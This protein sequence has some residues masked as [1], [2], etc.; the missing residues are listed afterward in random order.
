MTIATGEYSKSLES[1][2]SLNE[3]TWHITWTQVV[4]LAALGAAAVV[5]HRFLRIPLGLAGRH[6]V[7]WMML[8]VAGRALSRFRGASSI[9][10]ASAAGFSLMPYWGT[11]GEPLGWLTYLAAGVVIDLAVNRWP[12]FRA[13]LWAL[14]LLGALGHAMKPLL[15]AAVTLVT[16]I[17]FHSLLSGLLYPLST[18]LM[19]GAAGGFL[20]GVA[21]TGVRLVK[22]KT[23]SQPPVV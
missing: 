12:A 20:G 21:A 5:L 11:S 10:A 22:G 2:N 7:E 9:T 15:R 4:G 18:H 19:F 3:L 8:L 1:S 17:Q 6:G 23:R 14:I 16:G 13:K